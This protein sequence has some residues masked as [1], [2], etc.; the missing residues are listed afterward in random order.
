[1]TSPRRRPDRPIESVALK[2]TFRADRTITSKIKELVPSA[3]VR[4]GVCEVKIEAEHPAEVAEKARAIL[5]K[6]RAAS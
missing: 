6:I 4:G 5:E 2:I 1:M 3:A